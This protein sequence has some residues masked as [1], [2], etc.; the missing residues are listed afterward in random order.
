MLECIASNKI[1]F[2]ELTTAKTQKQEKNYFQKFAREHGEYMTIN[3]NSQTKK[4]LYNVLVLI[5]CVTNAPNSC[6]DGVR[7]FK[8]W[9]VTQRE[10]ADEVLVLSVF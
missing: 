3:F 10:S 7:Y 2:K 1:A 9:Q 8:N 4:M 5:H 6:T